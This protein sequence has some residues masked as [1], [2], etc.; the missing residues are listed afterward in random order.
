MCPPNGILAN[1]NFP[2]PYGFRIRADRDDRD[3]VNP[4]TLAIVPIDL[5]RPSLEAD[6]LFASGLPARVDDALRLHVARVL[7]E[8]LAQD[9]RPHVASDCRKEVGS[10]AASRRRLPAVDERDDRMDD[11]GDGP[12]LQLLVA[13]LLHQL[14]AAVDEAH[15][16]L[17]ALHVAPRDVERRGAAAARLPA[18]HHRLVGAAHEAV[19]AADGVEHIAVAHLAGVVDRQKGDA[20]FVGERLER[21]MSS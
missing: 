5:H 3:D 17:L 11:G 14:P 1:P 7:V 21:P 9:I 6:E 12:C 4:Y 10:G 18:E 19:R 16:E 20:P 2:I 15:A 13:H 8:V